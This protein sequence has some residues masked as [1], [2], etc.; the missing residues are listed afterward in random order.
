MFHREGWPSLVNLIMKETHSGNYELSSLPPPV[1]SQALRELKKF[2]LGVERRGK[3]KYNGVTLK[4]NPKTASPKEDRP[5]QGV[6]AAWKAP[7]S[8][9][10][11]PLL[12][13][14]FGPVVRP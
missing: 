9:L 2:K 12:T 1:V 4:G 3:R 14:I 6:R 7:V 5:A 8:M 13:E 10:V 11:L